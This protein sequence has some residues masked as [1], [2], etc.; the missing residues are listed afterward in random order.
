MSIYEETKKINELKDKEK[1]KQNKERE[2]KIKQFENM[3]ANH[4]YQEELLEEILPE[5]VQKFTNITGAYVG[6]LNFPPKDVTEKDTDENAHLNTEAEKVI[7]YI[8]SSISHKNLMRGKI[9][10]LNQGVTAKV[11][12]LAEE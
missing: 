12:T 8:G 7:N 10:K 11:F 3:V 4:E 1:Q 2:D 5:F 9:L 6:E